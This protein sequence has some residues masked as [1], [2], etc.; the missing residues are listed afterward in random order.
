MLARQASRGASAGARRSYATPGTRRLPPLPAAGAASGY[1]CAPAHAQS[2]GPPGCMH[3]W[4]PTAQNLCHFLATAGQNDK[5]H[6]RAAR[7]ARSCG[8]RRA[9][10]RRSAQLRRA[11]CQPPAWM[12]VPSS[13]TTSCPEPAHSHEH[14][15]CWPPRTE[16]AC[17]NSGKLLS[18]CV[19]LQQLAVRPC[20]FC[21]GPRAARRHCFVTGTLLQVN[22][23]SFSGVIAQAR[24]AP[25]GGASQS[26]AN[27]L[28]RRAASSSIT[29]AATCAGRAAPFTWARAR[30]VLT[31]RI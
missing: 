8:R 20:T 23:T 11:S 31:L 28:R 30:R 22:I 17:E 3:T 25:T 21:G 2:G 7:L 16:C 14:M 27:M 29:A 24:A 19:L 18:Q 15:R 26:G 5:A 6:C 4:R 12:R 1:G 13:S 10:V 9:V